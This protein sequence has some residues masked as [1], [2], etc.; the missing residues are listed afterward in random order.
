MRGTRAHLNRFEPNIWRETL[1]IRCNNC[2]FSLSLSLSIYIRE[3]RDESRG[4]TPGRPSF[5]YVFNMSTVAF[6]T[7]S[8]GAKHRFYALWVHAITGRY[9][10]YILYGN[11]IRVC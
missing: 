5:I 3:A 1:C 6:K 10:P 9:L 2:S 11:I 4:D 7:W 8:V